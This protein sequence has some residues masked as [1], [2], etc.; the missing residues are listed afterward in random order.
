[1]TASA[2]ATDSVVLRTTD[3][4]ATEPAQD[5]LF[6]DS[7][8][9]VWRATTPKKEPEDRLSDTETSPPMSGSPNTD[10]GSSLPRSDEDSSAMPSSRGDTGTQG[11]QKLAPCAEEFVVGDQRQPALSDASSGISVKAGSSARDTGLRQTGAD[12]CPRSTGADVAPVQNSASVEMIGRV[13]HTPSVDV[14]KMTR[15]INAESASTN[16]NASVIGAHVGMNRDTFAK[17][18]ACGGSVGGVGDGVNACEVHSGG[19]DVTNAASDVNERQPSSCNTVIPPANFSTQQACFLGIPSP[20]NS[21]SDRRI[22]QVLAASEEMY[23]RLQRTAGYVSDILLDCSESTL[24]TSVELYG[25]LSMV[26]T[27]QAH[28][29]RELEQDWANYYVNGRSDIDFVVEMAPGVAPCTVA[30]RLL[31]KGPWKLFGQVLVH[32]FASTQYTL[33]GS[34]GEDRDNGNGEG[35]P[36]EVYLD[37][38]CIEQP[39]HFDRFKKRQEAFRHAFLEVRS[40]MKAHYASQGVLAFDAY[41]HLLKAFAAKVP[42]SALTV[43]QATCIG[44]FTLQ[45]GHFKLKSIQSIA[46]SLFEGFLRFCVM[47]YAETQRSGYRHCAI[48]LSNGGRWLP[49]QSACWRSEVYFMSTEVSMGTRPND[50]MNVAHSLDPARV[51]S[52]AYALLQKA[53]SNSAAS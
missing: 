2:N 49:R 21:F 48:D 26:E 13:A 22:V 39:L 41:I 1:M 47:F 10:S 19:N 43:F 25:S 34:L 52:E 42:G 14:S 3:S 16:R 12:T 4:T 29:A 45:I 18:L 31:K 7:R 38:T 51:A 15:V 30:Q 46:L 9:E 40:R 20:S 8:R 44:L 50:R 35:K 24:A 27:L 32:K 33:L 23:R 36:S 17:P 5:G 53:F 28:T 6:Q 11:S 37:I